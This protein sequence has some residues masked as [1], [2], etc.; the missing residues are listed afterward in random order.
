MSFG[1]GT[2][3]VPPA[4]SSSAVER[5]ADGPSA[6]EAN[7]C[8]YVKAFPS[9]EAY[10]RWADRVDAATVGM[11]LADGVPVAAALAE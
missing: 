6:V 5:S 7:V 9:R 11:P 1:V 8:P 2:H 10:E 3:V 4:D